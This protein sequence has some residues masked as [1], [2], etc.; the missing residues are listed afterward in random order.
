MIGQQ[1]RDSGWASFY[2]FTGLKNNPY[3]IEKWELESNL[4]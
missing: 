4:K 3:G 1:L 2:L